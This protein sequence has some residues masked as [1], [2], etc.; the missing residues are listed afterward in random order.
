MTEGKCFRWASFLREGGSGR[1]EG[2]HEE[3]REKEKTGGKVWRI[4]LLV[5]TPEDLYD[6]KRG[7]GD[8]IREIS[9]GRGDAG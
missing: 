4:D 8:G 9:S 7:G 3:E 5:E 6:T 2:Q 1:N